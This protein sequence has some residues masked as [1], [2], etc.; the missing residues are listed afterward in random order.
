MNDVAGEEMKEFS[1]LSA[2]NFLDFVLEFARE[3]DR[4][5][6]VVING[7]R[8]DSSAIFDFL[9]DF[10]LIFFVKDIRSFTSDE[11][12]VE[13]TFGPILIMQTPDDWFSHPYDFEGNEPF[14]YLTRLENGLRF[15]LTLIDVENIPASFHEDDLEP[16][17]VLLKKD[18]MNF[19]EWHSNADKFNVKKPSSKQFQDTVN[20]F[21][22][23]ATY[24]AKGIWR[25]HFLY[26]KSIRENYQ[27]EMLLNMLNWS[28]AIDYGFNINTGNM[29]KYLHKYLPPNDWQELVACLSSSNLETA[30]AEER[31]MMNL[32]HTHA[33]K[34]SQYFGYSY[35]HDLLNR[36]LLYINEVE[37]MEPPA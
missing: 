37:Q 15:D 28:A 3:D 8:V 2:D 20:E 23:L 30:F 5:R 35:A 16:G 13:R 31:K 12:W 25:G 14:A 26:V 19:F 6:V 27:A 33:I 11:S 32:F 18:D 4:I 9:S 7:S 1:I 24:V 22:W 29:N 34:V 36:L 10:D 21:F 17:V